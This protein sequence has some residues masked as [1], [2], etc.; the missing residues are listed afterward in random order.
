MMTIFITLNT[1]VN[2]Y[3][4]FTLMQ[5]ILKGEVSTVLLTSCLT[6]LESALCLLTIFV[7][8]CKT[9]K[10]KPVKQKVNGT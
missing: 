4:V 10:S 6:C 1:G 8:I 7:F 9:N 5:G 3:N 2:T